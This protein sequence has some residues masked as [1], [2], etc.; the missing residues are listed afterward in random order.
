MSD[1]APV[2][3]ENDTAN[4]ASDG[5]KQEFE[6]YIKASAIDKETR[7]SCPICHQWFMIS[8]LMAEN[9]EGV[10]FKVFTVQADCPPKNFLEEGWSKKFPVVKARSCFT[11]LGKDISGMMYDT[12]EELETFFESINRDCPELKRHNAPNVG[13]MK[14][15]EDLYN[16]FNKFLSGKSES[17]LITELKKLEEFLESHESKFLV[18]D[19]LSFSDCH[20]LPRLQH[21]RVAGKAYK[22]FDI[23][24]E[25]PLVWKYLA[26]AYEVPA[27]KSTLPSDQDI[28]YGYEKKVTG[29]PVRG[30]GPKP[31]LEK[32]TYTTTVPQEYLDNGT[33]HNSHD[34]ME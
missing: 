22:D 31:T 11:K 19:V 20:L 7:G 25:F 18:D 5:P 15:I 26:D 4:G 1:E 29:A 24:K 3:Y 28:I 21:I 13:A 17:L 34:D 33:N 10:N 27:F 16:A 30:K 8:Y 32:F 9:Q 12:F 6:L 23:P 2:V 14:C